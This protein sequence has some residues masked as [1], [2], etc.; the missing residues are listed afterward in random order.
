MYVVKHKGGI[1]EAEAEKKKGHERET[2]GGRR[3][4]LE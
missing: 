1:L 3:A 4:V 2:E